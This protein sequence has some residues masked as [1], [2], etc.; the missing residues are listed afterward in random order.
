MAKPPAGMPPT[1]GGAESRLQGGRRLH[2]DEILC[3]WAPIHHCVLRPPDL[4][5]CHELHG[6]CDLLCVPHGIDTI[7]R[8]LQ[9]RADLEDKLHRQLPSGSAALGAKHGCSANLPCAAM[10]GSHLQGCPLLQGRGALGCSQAGVPQEGCGSQA[11]AAHRPG[12]HRG[13]EDSHGAG[14]ALLLH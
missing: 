2:L 13:R 10:H 14:D 4:G 9:P 11:V 5:C 7:P 1:P 8:I 6:V 12:P 3:K